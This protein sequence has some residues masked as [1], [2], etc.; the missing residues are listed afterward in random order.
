MDKPFAEGHGV[1]E[2]ALVKALTGTGKTGFDEQPSST[3]A[4]ERGTKSLVA[5]FF[6]LT[7]AALLGTNIGVTS[8]YWVTQAV[9]LPL[10][11]VLGVT[12]ARYSGFRV[13][14]LHPGLATAAV[15]FVAVASASTMWSEA[16]E[17]TAAKSTVLAVVVGSSLLFARVDAG[18][19][20]RTASADKHLRALVMLA[21]LW[22]AVNLAV[23]IRVGM[24]AESGALRGGCANP[25][26]FG[27]MTAL[28]AVPVLEWLRRKASGGDRTAARLL[29]AAVPG[30]IL[31]TYLSLSRGAMLLLVVSLAIWVMAWMRGQTVAF[32]VLMSATGV[33]FMFS[34][35]ASFQQRLDQFLFKT[36]AAKAERDLLASRRLNY[37]ESLAAIEGVGALGAGYGVAAG[38]AFDWKAVRTGTTYGYGREIA[39]SWLALREQ[40]G[41]PGQAIWI[42]MGAS[43]GATALRLR[44]GLPLPDRA[45]V[46]AFLGPAVGLYV[47][48]YYE[49][50]LVA[51]LSP[52]MFFFWTFFA[53]SMA[54]SH[55]GNRRTRRSAQESG[56]GTG[57]RS[58]RHDVRG[59]EPLGRLNGWSATD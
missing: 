42:L 26:A 49:A 10:T 38:E 19:T 15:S 29:T 56:E 51:P 58:G 11:M 37:D 21:I 24:F 30:F 5:W 35:S 46:G 57:L 39:N 34:T 3:R 6:F 59:G 45:R 2:A 33:A 50:W 17:L 27:A 40:L 55:R 36:E 9:R 22:G 53:C 31:A 28:L 8:V 7:A 16:P 1:S 20:R 13:R 32:I 41:Y 52:E 14:V 23:G 47:Q 54:G 18:E 25:N 48:S 12:A 4:R 43:L 44:R